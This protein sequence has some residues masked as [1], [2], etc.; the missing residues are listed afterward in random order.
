MLTV[1]YY[2]AIHSKGNTQY[3]IVL[4][5]SSLASTY[6]CKVTWSPEANS[7]SNE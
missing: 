7:D 5:S 6:L 4:Y 1:L 2:I 3:G